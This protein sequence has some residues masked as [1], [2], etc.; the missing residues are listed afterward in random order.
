MNRYRNWMNR[1]TPPPGFHRR[2]MDRLESAGRTRRRPARVLGTAAAAACLTLAVVLLAAQGGIFWPERQPDPTAGV[3][4]TPEPVVSRQTPPPSQPPPAVLPDP[5][6]AGEETGEPG[7]DAAPTPSPTPAPTPQATPAPAPNAVTV[8]DPF[9]GRPHGDLMLEGHDFPLSTD[10]IQGRSHP[11]GTFSEP[12]TG[13]EILQVLGGGDAPPWSLYWSDFTLWGTVWYG[14]DGSLWEVE[15]SGQTEDVNEWFHLRL[16]P[17]TL[18]MASLPGVPAQ[19]AGSGGNSTPVTAWSAQSS[20]PNTPK[21]MYYAAFLSGDIGVL[22]SSASM[23]GQESA[24]L[25]AEYVIREYAG[26]GAKLSLDHL[27]CSRIPDWRDETLTLEQAKAEALGAYLPQTI[28]ERYTFE[29]AQILAKDGTK[30]EHMVVRW[31]N[32]EDLLM[33]V[34]QRLPDSVRRD[35]DDF[36]P[37]EV[38]PEALEKHALPSTSIHGP[39]ASYSFR[40]YRDGLYVDYYVGGLTYEEAA[41]LVKR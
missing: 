19:P 14:G 30:G 10:G 20:R 15:I 28:P 35:G 8:T 34:V 18:P 16:A 36:L 6:G 5:D 4:R 41:A 17:G 13:E 2:L 11:E 29:M 31:K 7:P 27:Q 1:M 23:T 12:M 37:E 25:R 40:V 38:T 3:A 39:D 32:G 22:F 21:G 33:V 9:E 24:R 26:P